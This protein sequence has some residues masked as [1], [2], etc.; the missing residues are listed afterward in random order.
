MLSSEGSFHYT[1]SHLEC[2]LGFLLTLQRFP[3]RRKLC[4]LLIP[5]LFNS[6]PDWVFFHKNLLSVK[7]Q[8]NISTHFFL[9]LFL[10]YDCYSILLSIYLWSIYVRCCAKML[11]YITPLNPHHNPTRSYRPYFMEETKAH[12]DRC[13]HQSSCSEPLYSLFW[14]KLPHSVWQSEGTSHAI[15]ELQ[16]TFS[17]NLTPH[18]G[19]WIW[20]TLAQNITSAFYEWFAI[21]RIIKFSIPQFFYLRNGIILIASIQQC[22]CIKWKRCW[23]PGT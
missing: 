23:V 12:P 4:N 2:G 20:C 21:V 17:G 22:C 19:F 9:L 8:E 7:D 10:L 11:Y 18:S 1:P 3:T 15:F 6:L 13:Q 14:A 5:N 16:V